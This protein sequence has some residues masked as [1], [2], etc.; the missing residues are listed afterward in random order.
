[1]TA[2][3]LVHSAAPVAQPKP[4]ARPLLHAVKQEPCPCRDPSCR[5]QTLWAQ[6]S[7]A[8]GPALIRC[9]D[10]IKAK[11]GD[12][13]PHED[14]T[15]HEMTST[16]GWLLVDVVTIEGVDLDGNTIGSIAYTVRRLPSGYEVRP[17]PGQSITDADAEHYRDAAIG[18]WELERTI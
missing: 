7:P 4:S 16:R 11:P 5:A 2:L 18:Q 15:W 8:Y 10:R 12:I 3:R 14:G 9:T 1:V 13:H 17:L 6:R